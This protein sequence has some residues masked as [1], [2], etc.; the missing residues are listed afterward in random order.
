M[1]RKDISGK[2]FGQLTAINPTG[3]KNRHGKSLWNCVCSCGNS[4]VVNVNSLN[5]GNTKTCGCGKYDGMKIYVESK[6]KNAFGIHHARARNTWSKMIDRCENS[7]NAD[8]PN[9]GGRGISVCARWH[10][11]EHFVQD[12]GDPPIGMTLDRYPNQDGNYEP[13]NCRWATAQQQAR[14]TRRNVLVDYYGEVICIAELA[15]RTGVIAASLYTKHRRLK[16]QGQGV[17]SW[18]M[19]E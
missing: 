6:K 16:N 3:E 8:Y 18:S 4:T 11:L 12:M 13:D 15:L 1:A 10:I 19:L 7:S 14:N 2:I 9:Y 5:S 17:V